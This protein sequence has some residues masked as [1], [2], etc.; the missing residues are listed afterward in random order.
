METSNKNYEFWKS[1]SL[2][3]ELYS[4]D[5]AFQKLNYIHNNPLTERWQLANELSDYFYSSA[6]F[7]ESGSCN[8][9]FLKNLAEEL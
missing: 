1:D 3:I 5:V 8:F 6:C 9:T 7:Y 4:E 2:A